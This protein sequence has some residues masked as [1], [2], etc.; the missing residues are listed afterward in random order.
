MLSLS[1]LSS[2]S[3]C[4]SVNDARRAFPP[5]VFPFV[6]FLNEDFS[7]HLYTRSEGGDSY[8]VAKVSII[9]PPAVSMH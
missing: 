5:A 2:L 1:Q 9:L 3:G 8:P 7:Q 6:V 4:V